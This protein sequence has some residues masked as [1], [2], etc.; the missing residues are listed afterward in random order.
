MGVKVELLEA[1]KHMKCQPLDDPLA[2]VALNGGDGELHR[3]SSELSRD[4]EIWM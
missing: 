1:N 4:R 3:G 2:S